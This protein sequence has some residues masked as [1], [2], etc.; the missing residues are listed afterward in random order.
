MNYFFA[1]NVVVWSTKTAGAAFGLVL[2]FAA[3]EF[4]KNVASA[5]W[6]QYC[7]SSLFRGFH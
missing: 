2:L 1:N 7:G 3:S 5:S 6:A 4:C